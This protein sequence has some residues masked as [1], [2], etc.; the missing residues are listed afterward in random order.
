[1]PRSPRIELADELHHVTAKTPSGRVLFIDD[2]DRKRYLQLLA[3]EVRDREWSVLT[4]C[5]MTNHLHALVRT[6]APDLGAGFKR[7]HENFARHLNHR[8]RM[9]GHVFGARFHSKL[10]RSD[11][12]LLGCLR[13]IARNPVEAGVC[14]HARQWRWSA[15]RALARLEPP[16]GFLDV[17]AAYAFLDGCADDA[18]ANY[19]RLVAQSN[20]ALLA[21]LGRPDSDAWLVAALDE[22][23]IP[24]PDIARFLG[25]AVST[26][27]RRLAVAREN[28]GT[29]PSVS[30]EG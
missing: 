27:Y 15:H 2:L 28:E 22:F 9:G 14:S 13:Y 29:D 30:A 5:L 16:P 6:P 12:H 17:A 3:R 25:I 19:L 1:M 11:G 4:Y 10:V 24:V 21:D 18:R 8:H 26:A 7:I 23:A 20:S